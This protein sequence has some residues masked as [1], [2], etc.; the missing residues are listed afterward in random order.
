MVDGFFIAKNIAVIGASRSRGKVGNVVF[1]VLQERGIHTIPINPNAKRIHGGRCYPSVLSYKGK[2]DMAVVAIPAPFVP[3]VVEECGEKGIKNVVV[4]SAGFSESGKEGVKLEKKLKQV[5]DEYSIKLLGPNCLGVINPKRRL[6]ASFFAGMPPA[7]DIAF[8]SQSGAL[9]VAMLDYSIKEKIGLSKF[10]SVGNMLG[11]NF[12]EI[13]EYLNKDEDTK[14]ICLYIESLKDGRKFLDVAKR[15]DKLIITLKAGKSE[16]GSRAAS[17]HTGAL[18]GS[19]EVYSGAFK[20]A[21]II[22]V[23]SLEKLFNVAI[24]CAAQ[25]RPSGNRV[26]IVTNAGGP[27]VM[28]ADACEHLGLKVA[29][30]PRNLVSELNEKLPPHWSHNNPIDVVGDATSKRYRHVFNSID[31][32]LF[33]STI[34]IVTPQAMT[35]VENIVK[36]GLRFRRR[37]KKPV[38]FCLMGG[39]RVSNGIKMVKEADLVNFSEPTKV[40][41]TIQL[42]HE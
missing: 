34:I 30:L 32:S 13:I 42:L 27:G 41:R 22:E 20:Q 10:V 35:D 23:N 28:A 5:V 4:I 3:K 18:A 17:S 38:Y 26:L 31:P 36:E 24:S 9:A 11:V 29:R 2:I 7:G 25:G 6:N 33:D 39:K 12:A 1:K 14:C 40:A 16:S 8:V 37:V 19:A 21:G 15:L